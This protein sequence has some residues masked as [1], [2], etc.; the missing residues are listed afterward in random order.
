MGLTQTGTDGIKDDAITLAKQAAG[1]D[2]QI[3]TYDASGNPVAVGPGTD[4]QVLTSTGAGSPP[5]FEDIPAAGAALTGST[6]NTIT[7]VTGANAIQ[8]EANLTF[9]GNDLTVENGDVQIGTTSNHTKFLRFADGTRVDAST[10]KVDNSNS[11][12]LITNNRGTGEIQFATNSAERVSIDTSGHLTVTDGDLVIGTAGH[13]IDFS[14]QSASS[15]GTTGDEV[16]NHY[17]EGTFTPILNFGGIG[18]TSYNAATN[19]TYTR[20]GRAVHFRAYVMLSAKGGSTGTAKMHGLPFSNNSGSRYAVLSTW[21]TNMEI[22]DPHTLL[23][24]VGNNASY[25][26]FERYNDSNGDGAAVDNTHFNDNSE[27]M[28]AGTYFT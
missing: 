22:P 1:T 20:I 2:G 9:D 23:A 25:V 8:G 15:T 19:G 10:I 5:A 17:E 16:L 12:L 7:T 14:A 27:F 6:N 11:N 13:G 26:V 21:C 4:G 28:V 24:Y 3:I 18:V